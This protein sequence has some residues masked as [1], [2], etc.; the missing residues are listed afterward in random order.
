MV[1]REE[2]E[3]VRANDVSDG[4][5]PRGN[6]QSTKVFLCSLQENASESE[7]HI[8]VME[9]ASASQMK[10]LQLPICAHQCPLRS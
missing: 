10:P 1:E 3:R 7:K 4:V 9:H 8:M 2:R 6:Y 5:I